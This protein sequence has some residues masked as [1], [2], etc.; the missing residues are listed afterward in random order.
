MELT[1]GDTLQ[2]TAKV[3]PANTSVPLTWRTSDSN[4]AEVDENGLVITKAEGT[5][6]INE[7]SG[8]ISASCKL[9]GKA[10]AYVLGDVN[11]DGDINILDMGL[12]LRAVCRK[13]E[14]TAKQQL[15]ADVTENSLVNIEDLRMILRYICGKI[16]E[17]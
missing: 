15:A 2:L 11:R 12:V 1:R 17:L 13:V 6:V 5:A 4:V 14:L 16:E 9:M 10:P 3:Q 8:D 7:Q